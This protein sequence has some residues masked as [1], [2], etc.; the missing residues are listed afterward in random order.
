MP[1]TPNPPTKRTPH[2]KSERAREAETRGEHTWTGWRLA[3][4]MVHVL[5]WNKGGVTERDLR[6]VRNLELLKV[7]LLVPT[8]RHHTGLRMPQ[9]V[10]RKQDQY[11]AVDRTLSETLTA[12]DLA[13]WRKNAPTDDELDEAVENLTG[14]RYYRERR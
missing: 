13:S 11:Y 5:R 9:P 10:K 12:G 2:N 1:L 14:K 4:L 3:E 7:R 6:R 8:E